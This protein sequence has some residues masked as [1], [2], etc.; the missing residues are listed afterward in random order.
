MSMATR[1]PGCNPELWGGVECTINRIGNTF[2]DQLADTGHYERAGDLEAIAALGIRML[3]YPVLWEKHQPQKNQVID[4]SWAN[5]QLTAMRNLNIQPI[6]GLVHHGSGP[7]YTS[8]HDKDFAYGLA[9]YAQEVATRFAWI[10]YYTPVNEPL[11]T[12]RFSGLYGLWYPHH[13][14][15]ASFALMLVNQVKATILAMQAIRKINPAAKLVQTEDITKI[16]STELLSYQAGFENE[17]RWLSFDLLCGRVNRQHYF[18]PWFITHGISEQQLEFFIQNPC[19]PDIMGVNYYVTSE[20]YLDEKLHDHPVATHGGNGIH[21]YADIAAVHAGCSTG[22]NNLLHETW[23]RYRLPIAITEAHLSCT[24]EEQLRWFNYIWEAGCQAK[25]QAIDIRAV[26]AWCLLGAYDWNSLLTRNNKFYETG[27]FDAGKHTLRPT[28][29]ARHIQTLAANGDAKHPLLLSKGWWQYKDNIP[30]NDSRSS[31]GKPPPLL[32]IGK[33]GTLAAAFARICEKRNIP[34]KALSRQDIDIRREVEIHKAIDRYKPWAV[35][36]ASGFVQVDEAETKPEECFMLNTVAPGLLARA[37]REHGI[38]F[39]T[40]SSDLV[41]N[42]DKKHPYIESDGTTPLNS[43]GKS[44]A[45][46]EAIVSGIYPAALIIRTSAF[47]GPWDRY[48]F[49]YHILQQLE[50]QQPCYAVNDVVVSPTYVPDLVNASLDL[51]IDEAEGIWHLSNNGKVTWADFACELAERAGYSAASIERK[52]LKEMG[53]K[54][55]RPHYSVLESDKGIQL[56]SLSHALQ[57]YFEEKI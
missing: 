25:E 22:L 26:T 16:H 32:I 17:R 45:D 44:K 19:V 47:F 15:A 34:Y 36:N 13:K 51:F 53:W 41:F 21:T 2:R 33:H 6:A 55:K 42:G 57:R 48:N 3:R 23:N 4:W 12:A 7:A 49:A 38:R 8:L 5:R 24:R 1:Y 50:Q 9:R 31:A 11:T 18:W 28:A 29:I 40:F 37:C 54:A 27:V 10:N 52:M 35:V 39:M 43:Y 56:P 14:Q 20:R 46:G 30:A